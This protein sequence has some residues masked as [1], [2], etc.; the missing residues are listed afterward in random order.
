MTTITAATHS[1]YFETNSLRVDHCPDA[2]VSEVPEAL[3]AQE[4]QQDPTELGLGW[5]QTWWEVADPRRNSGGVFQTLFRGETEGRDRS[6]TAAEETNDDHVHRP[7]LP[8]YG[9]IRGGAR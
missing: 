4:D 1:D 9:G 5:R 7:G 8:V 3:C 6:C 2:S